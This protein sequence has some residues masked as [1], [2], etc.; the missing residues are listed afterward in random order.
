MMA[1][2]LRFEDEKI[3]IFFFLIQNRRDTRE[4]DHDFNVNNLTFL[5]HLV[6]EKKLF[7]IRYCNGPRDGKSSKEKVD[8]WDLKKRI[9]KG[10]V[11]KL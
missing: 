1:I 3:W 5:I 8:A 7:T 10:S 11:C 2:T 6:V 4:F 9:V